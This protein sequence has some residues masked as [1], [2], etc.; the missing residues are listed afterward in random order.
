MEKK[1]L[2]NIESDIGGKSLQVD[3]PVVVVFN[4]WTA[5]LWKLMNKID[6]TGIIREN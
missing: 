4:Q 2:L 1:L 6:I 3:T 5:L